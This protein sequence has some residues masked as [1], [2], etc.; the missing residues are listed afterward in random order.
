MHIMPKWPYIILVLQ[1]EE[2]ETIWDEQWNI[3]ILGLKR[4]QVGSFEV[5]VA[6][7]DLHTWNH[8]KP[9]GPGAA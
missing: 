2:L 3:L 5:S 4:L 8:E 9:P 7:H 6:N 1:D